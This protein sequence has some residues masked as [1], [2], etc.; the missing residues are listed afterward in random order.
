MLKIVVDGSADMPAD[1][2]ERYQFD[3]LPMPIQIGNRTYYQGEDISPEKFYQLV[4]VTENHPQTAAPSP[5]RIAKFIEEVTEIGDTVLSINVS[6]KMSS[7]VAM[8]QKAEKILIE[9]VKM[10]VFDSEAGSAVLAFMAREA[11]LREQAGE[12]LEQILEVLTKIRDQVMV[13]LTLD[14]LDFARR[15][16]RVGSIKAAL[17]SILKIKPIISLQSGLLDISDMVRSRK[18]SLTRLVNKVQERFGTQEIK[19]AIVH[20]QDSETADILKEMVTNV[21]NT[22]EV[23]FTEL[24]ISVAANLGPGTVGIVALPENI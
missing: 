15:S 24:S 11:R 6:G 23:I 19:V 21:A 5:S 20:A 3:I 16:G 4:E 18:K 13:V 10:V 17:T 8:V 9:K 2:P 14:T 12:S 22:T 1:W 7:T